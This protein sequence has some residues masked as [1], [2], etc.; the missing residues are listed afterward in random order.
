MVPL[1]ESERNRI[2]EQEELGTILIC[3][4]AAGSF[5]PMTLFSRVLPT[6]EKFGYPRERTVFGF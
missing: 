4:V 5:S 1:R 3:E 6:A 2:E